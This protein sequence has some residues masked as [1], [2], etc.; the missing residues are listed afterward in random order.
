MYHVAPTTSSFYVFIV[1]QF[2]EGYSNSLGLQPQQLVTQVFIRNL[3]IPIYAQPSWTM[4]KII[5]VADVIT[6]QQFG[7]QK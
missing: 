7:T 4:M 1:L 5:I 2:Y 3:L 6:R